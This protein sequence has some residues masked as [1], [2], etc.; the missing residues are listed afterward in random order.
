MQPA[1]KAGLRVKVLSLTYKLL[2]D[3][4]PTCLAIAFGG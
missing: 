1:E 4:I 3:R 2:P